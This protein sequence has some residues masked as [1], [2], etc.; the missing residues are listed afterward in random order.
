ME[1]RGEVEGGPR[2][3]GRPN[4]RHSLVV[5]RRRV[6][7]LF[8]EKIHEFLS[9][10]IHVAEN[11]PKRSS[12]NIFSWVPRDGCPPAVRMLEHQMRCSALRMFKKSKL[13][14]DMDKL[15]VFDYRQFGHFYYIG[16]VTV[17]RISTPLSSGMDSPSL[18]KL[19]R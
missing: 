2:G 16:A 19:R 10:D 1:R 3:T 12:R 4:L 13:M 15:P 6:G 11:G 17:S 9:R 14:Q 5:D 8:F 7:G 18:F